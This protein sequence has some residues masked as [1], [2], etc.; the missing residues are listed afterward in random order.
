MC[1]VFLLDPKKGTPEGS[2]IFQFPTQLKSDLYS[3]NIG[4]ALYVWNVDGFRNNSP[5]IC[6]LKTL[7]VSSV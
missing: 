1:F 5:N 4:P 7:C 6:G 2:Q 3:Q